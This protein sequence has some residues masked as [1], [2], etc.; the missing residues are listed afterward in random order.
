MI[1]KAK[2]VKVLFRFKSPRGTGV[3]TTMIVRGKEINIPAYDQT[4][5]CG[6]LK[7]RDLLKGENLDITTKSR[8]NLKNNERY[9]LL[10]WSNQ[11]DIIKSK[12]MS[13]LLNEIASGCLQEIPWEEEVTDCDPSIIAKKALLEKIYQRTITNRLMEEK[14]EENINE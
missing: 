11:N 12:I 3:M 8:A 5:P 6:L 4:F 13:I 2:F 1:T 9:E 10:N 7:F 14:D